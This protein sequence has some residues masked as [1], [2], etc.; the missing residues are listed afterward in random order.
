[1]RHTRSLA[2]LF[3]AFA[4]LAAARAQTAPR[5]DPIV[6]AEP[7]VVTEP[8]LTESPATVTRLALADLPQTE[9]S[10]PH[11]AARAAN[12]FESTNDAHSFNDTFSL[13]GLTNTPIFGDPAISFYLDDLPLGSG[14]TFPTDLAG[15]AQA[16]LHRGPSQN[17]VFGRAGSAGVVTLTTPEPAANPSGELRAS[18]G[19]YAARSVSATASTA[20][21]PTF[22][23]YVSAAYSARDGYLTNTRLG[24]DIDDKES[25]SALARFR[26]RPSTASEFTLLVTAL[27][28]RDGVQPLVP[29]GG[30]LFTVTRKTEGYTEVDATNAALKAAFTT[31]LGLLSATTSLTNWELGPY[32][33]VLAFGPSE[34]FNGSAL[35]QRNWNEEVKLASPSASD[36][37][38]QVGAIYTD[39]STDGSFTRAFGPFVIEKSTYRIDARDLAAFGEATF[40]INSA[41]RFTAGLRAEDSRKTMLRTEFIPTPQVFD[42]RR[43]STALLPKF[44][45]S[46]APDR[47][48]SFF[49][50]LGAGYKPGGFSAFTGNRALASFGPE[51]TKTLEAG[52]TQSTAD[53]S[54][55][56]T[57]RFF[58]YDITGYQIERSFATTAVADDYLVVNAPRARSFGGELELAWR[59]LAGL[60]LAADLGTTDVTLRDFRD[61]YTGK[62]FN[63]NR[64]PSVPLYDASLRA[65]YA[66]RSGFFGG[67]ELTSNGRTF[68]T[69][70]ENLKFGQRAYALLGARLG[71]A[72]GRY[73]VTAYGEN[74]TD[75][76]YYSAIAPGTGHGTPGAPRTYGVEVAVKW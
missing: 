71:Y 9:I 64:A 21:S 42:L 29:L 57:L 51:R 4:A 46:Y 32:A 5:P 54:L 69:E 47:D 22:D 30:P 55:S 73:R 74:L 1:M 49:A 40:K 24:R 2:S 3:L 39:G 50:S 15:F 13:R 68:Y 52:V 12:F 37:R 18:Y 14:F 60:T 8:L 11:L 43:E 38:W 66:H 56:A 7:V 20:S 33:S 17:T 36:V 61:P 63:G 65:D 76:G 72:A 10:L 44:A 34:L 48:T 26:F 31:P 23:A 41:L 28:A 35:K 6:R 16:E 58:Y 67:L 25:T 62:T 70:A 19:N 45:A 53:K 59:P 27:R 75:I